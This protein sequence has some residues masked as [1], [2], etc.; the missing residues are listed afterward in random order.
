LNSGFLVMM[1]TVPPGSPRQKE[2]RSDL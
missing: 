1:L 2:L